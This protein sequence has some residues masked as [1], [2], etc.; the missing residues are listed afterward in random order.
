MR[1]TDQQRALVEQKR[2]AAMITLRPDGMPHA[3]RVGLALVQGQLWSSGTRVMQNRPAGP[4]QWSGV[5]T[6]EQEFLER[7][8]NEKRLIYQFEPVRVYGSI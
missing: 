6:S 7:M 2:G 8:A 1:L 3:V 5:E 4:L